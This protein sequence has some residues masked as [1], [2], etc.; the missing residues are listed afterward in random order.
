MPV[1]DLLHIMGLTLKSLPRLKE[2]IVGRYREKISRENISGFRDRVRVISKQLVPI[3]VMCM[4]VPERY[5]KEQPEVNKCT[6]KDKSDR[7]K[8]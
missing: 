5:F 4:Q 2:E 6:T 7:E 3:F 1:D 8:D